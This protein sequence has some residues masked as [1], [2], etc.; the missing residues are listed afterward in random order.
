MNAEHV[1]HLTATYPGRKASGRRWLRWLPLFV[2][3]LIC[4]LPFI[5]PFLWMVSGAFK[6]A[7]ELF[8]S[9]PNLLP[10][11]LRWNNFVEAFEYQPFARHYF[12]SLYIAV[13]VTLGTLIVASMSGYAFARIRFPLRSVLFIGLLSALMMPVEVTII[14]NFY[15]M[16]QLNLINTHLPLIILPIFGP[17]S[18]AAMFLI[19]QFFLAFPRELEEAAMIDGLTRWGIFWRIALPIAR[20]VLAAVTITTFLYSWNAFLEPLVFVDDLQLFTLSLS[21]RN[22]RDTYGVP[23]WNLQL[24]ATTL[25][26]IPILIVYLIAQRQV[27]NSFAS[28][29]I[30][31]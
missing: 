22:F 16:T 26:I 10:D 19:R 28:S 9:P 27:I 3:L 5:F 29:G 6:T 15:F 25:S 14:P 24:A 20:P 8:A 1:P 23:L 4:C 31:G 12:N 18:I 30:K 11:Q 13:L 17:N 2:I 21:L 7:A